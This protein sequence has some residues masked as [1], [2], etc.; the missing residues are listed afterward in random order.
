MTETLQTLGA[1]LASEAPTPTWETTGPNEEAL[2][3]TLCVGEVSKC[4]E[5]NTIK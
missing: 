1:G 3:M 5:T 2:I 4:G